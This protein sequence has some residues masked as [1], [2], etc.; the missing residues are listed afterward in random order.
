VLPKPDTSTAIGAIAD[1]TGSAIG[2]GVGLAP[3]STLNIL[4]KGTRTLGSFVFPTLEHTPRNVAISTPLG[5][6]TG[7]LAE[8]EAAYKGEPPLT[9]PGGE[10]AIAHPPAPTPATV[11]PPDPASV[12]ATPPAAT[13]AAKQ[14][15]DHVQ[16]PPPSLS[17]LA[18]A[19]A[20]ATDGS[21][22]AAAFGGTPETPAGP[23]FTQQGNTNVPLWVP[24]TGL[25]ATAAGVAAG[26]KVARRGAEVSVA[27]RQARFN[28]PAYAAEKAAYDA[29]VISRGPGSSTL[30]P[31]G[32]TPTPAPVPR[33]NA[34]RRLA[35]PQRMQQ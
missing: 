20:P 31:P 14:V 34:V 26:V 15:A 23:T 33:G 2:G 9:L 30:T 5:M 24:I 19:P 21:L 35:L 1:T 6:G 29:D 7:T 11:P 22:S 12:A 18:F 13:T 16:T 28:D 25:L 8:I 32:G 3:A 27:D 4:P 17:A 10:P